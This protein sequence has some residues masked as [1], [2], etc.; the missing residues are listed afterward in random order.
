MR[1]IDKRPKVSRRGF[2]GA[3]SASVIALTILPTGMIVAADRSWAVMASTL[4]PETFAT[5]VQM[6]RDI[7]PHD[8]LADA[9]YAKAVQAFDDAASKSEDSKAMFEDGVT[10]LNEAAMGAHG[11]PY[12][13]VGWEEQRVAILRNMQKSPFFQAVR[14]GL[15]TGIYNNPEV[16]PLF[17][18]EGESA[19]KGGYINRGF[20]DIDWLDQV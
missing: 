13:Q 3:G 4:N 18:Y 2:L 14:G 1:V 7:Y 19:S 5:L 8:R 16:W 12:A 17:G 20:D 10:G 9:Y 6:S 11:V 15:I